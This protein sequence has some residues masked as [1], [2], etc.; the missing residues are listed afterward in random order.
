MLDVIRERAQGWFAK[1][2]LALITVPFALWGV[3]SYL[4]NGGEGAIVAKVNGQNI[5]KQEFNQA[6]KEQNERMRRAMGASFDPSILEKPETRMAILDNLIERRLMDSSAVK[7]GVVAPDE[8]LVKL[9]AEVPEFQEG[10]KFSQTRYEALLRNQS[11][12]PAMFESRLRQSLMTERLS[13][14][15]IDSTLI[16]HVA[17]QRYIHINEMQ[18]EITQALVSPEQFMPQIK[19]SPDDIKAYYDKHKEEFRVPEQARLEYVVLSAD[20]LMQ[21]V[22]VTDEEVKKYYDEHP[23]QFQE[24]EQRQASH[25]LI[26]ASAKA[27][28]AEI[29][30]TREKAEK[31]A[32]EAKQAP[33]NFAELAK[34]LSQDTGSATNGGDLGFF[35]R[36]AMVKPFEDA[37]FKMAVGEISEPVQSDFGFHVIKLSAVKPGKLRTLAEAGEEIALA[38]KKQKAG[39]R[40]AEVAEGFSNAVYEQSDSLKPA[41]EAL[42]LKIQTSSWIDKKGSGDVALLNNGK[43]LQAVFSDESLKLKR[44]T[45]ALEVSPN[46]LV[47]ARVVEFKPSSYKL[48]EGLSVE[49]G[50][51]LQRE[52]ANTQ[53]VKRGKE[54]L[55]QLR[56]GKDAA[57][58]KWSAP[59]SI[60]RQAA[61]ASLGQVAVGEIFKADARK[62]PVYTGVADPKGGYMVIKVNRV[63]EPGN[64]DDAKKKSYTERL[65]QLTMQEYHT[66]Y[67]ASLKQKAEIVIKKEQLEK[68]DR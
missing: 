55:E 28:A 27:S 63:V 60:S 8:L 56:L 47:S 62:L 1:V 52:L 3:D 19:V 36:G 51:R 38:L 35:A 16:S 40:F 54:A 11:M 64:L 18:R 9:I 26:N 33:G 25:I 13:N 46:T 4:R 31:I 44:N 43:L 66:A 21:Q 2:I 34:K 5:S 68:N 29:A 20:E 42:K 14:S 48:L 17:T 32:K 7:A 58:L 53:A 41:A 59:I 23:A 49:L 24:Q 45:E 67:V 37:V 39:K 15:L 22:T 30:A 57:D 6:L 61:A 50:A 65:R 10:G 12:T